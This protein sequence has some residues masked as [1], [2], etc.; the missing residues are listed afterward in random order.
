MI[1]VDASVLIDALRTH[2]QK[3][4]QLFNQRT[5]EICGVTKAEILHRAKRQADLQKLTA[6]LAPFPR[7]PIPDDLWDA[8]GERL[9]LLRI[10]GLTVPFQDVV[11]VPL[12]IANDIELWARDAHLPDIQKILPQ[13]KL[14]QE[15]P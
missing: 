12:A 15:P 8:V 5:A 3:L 9:Y 11:L 7:V 13:L 4:Y 1:L 2:S 14:S 10:N 6:S